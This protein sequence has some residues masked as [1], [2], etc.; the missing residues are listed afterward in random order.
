[1]KEP[2]RTLNT[3][4]GI[5]AHLGQ[6]WVNRSGELCVITEII[7]ATMNDSPTLV[8]EVTGR[9]HL[10]GLSKTKFRSL[11]LMR[12]ATINEIAEQEGRVAEQV[13]RIEPPFG[14]AETEQAHDETIMSVSAVADTPL[15]FIDRR[16]P[17]NQ[18]MSADDAGRLAVDMLTDLGWHFRDGVWVQD[19][20]DVK[21]YE[22]LRNVFTRAFDQASQ[23][24]GKERHESDDLPFHEQQMQT[25]AKIFGVGSLLYQAFKK[26]NE[27]QRLPLNHAVNEMLGAIV[28]IA[29]AIIRRELDGQ[30]TKK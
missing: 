24:K 23:G 25:G 18:T 2:L 30:E 16:N 17:H 7:R 29:G 26:T 14:L 19:S 27:S 13:A 28:Y 21:G 11:D 5:R 8:D 10:N 3:I 4:D 15:P 22:L 6:R 1:M 12:L 20:A 9:Y